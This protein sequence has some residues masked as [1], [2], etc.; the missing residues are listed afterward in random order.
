MTNRESRLS[1]ALDESARQEFL[2]VCKKF[3]L[4]QSQVL[5]EAINLWMKKYGEEEII[6]TVRDR[7]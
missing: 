2:A 1:L 4:S 6:F 7:K 3:N 5:R